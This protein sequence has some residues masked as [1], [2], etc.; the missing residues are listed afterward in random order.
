MKPAHAPHSFSSPESGG[1]ALRVLGLEIAGKTNPLITRLSRTGSG[2]FNLRDAGE[3]RGGMNPA[4]LLVDV[5]S[6]NR[7]ELKSFL[8]CQNCDVQAAADGESAVRCCLQM[9]PDV[10]LLYD[11]LPGTAS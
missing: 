3:K 11:N 8:Q 5:A 9:Q 4:V 2:V 7:E 6:T 10:I 1:R